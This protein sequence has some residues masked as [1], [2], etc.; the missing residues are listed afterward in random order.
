MTSTRQ[1]ASKFDSYMR[2]TRL[3]R[4]IGIFLVAWPMLWA[5]WLAAQGVPNLW[6]LFV[7]IIGSILMRSAGCVMNDYADRHI[8]GHVKRTRTRPLATGEVGEREALVL[9]AILC[10]VAF[11]LTLTLNVLTIIMACIGLGLAVLYPFTKRM[12]HW[13]Q[14]FLG[15]AFG[16]AVPMAFAAQAE[17]VPAGGWVL[18]VA[19]LIWALIYD[20]FYAMVD[21]D[22]DLKIGVK[23]TAVLWG[24]RDLVYIGLF[25]ILFYLLLIVVGV[26][27]SLGFFYYLGLVAAIGMSVY[28]Q[29][30]ARGREREVCFKVF[31]QHNFLGGIIFVGLLLDLAF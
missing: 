2:L 27:F 23:S 30:I 3:N 12:T 13:P 16:W 18:F 4:P 19:T 20:T 31:M 5:V 9:F 10:L 28:H 21:R 26:M 17:H 7:L 29:W 8:D 6:V 14:S 11:L 22:D 1:P 25:Q 15:L 24:D